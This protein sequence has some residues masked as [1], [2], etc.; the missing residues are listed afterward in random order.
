MM[1]KVSPYTRSLQKKSTQEVYTRS[2]QKKSTEEVYIASDRSSSI[3]Q[4]DS[5]RH[6]DNVRHKRHAGC[7]EEPVEFHRIRCLVFY[8]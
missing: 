8:I 7:S 3:T 4:D 6:A 2:L 1:Q 5:S